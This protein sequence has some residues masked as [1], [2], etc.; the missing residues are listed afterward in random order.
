VLHGRPRVAAPVVA[1]A[2][3]SEAA[4]APKRCQIT[5]GSYPW[6]D[7]WIDG[8]ATGLQTPVVSMPISCGRH[9]L[10]FK[11]RDLKVDQIESVTVNEGHELKR[12]VDLQ[13]ADE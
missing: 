8:V 12:Q 10:E 1:E 11:R 5:V 2:Q 6:A 7:L 4:D 3:P 9:R 13:G